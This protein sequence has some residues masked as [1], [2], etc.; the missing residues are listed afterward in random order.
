[1]T[2]VAT[3]ASGELDIGIGGLWVRLRTD[4]PD[5]VAEDY[6]VDFANRFLPS[7]LTLQGRRQMGYE[8]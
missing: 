6:E 3:N 2:A 4:S 8:L 5:F 1:M 7:D